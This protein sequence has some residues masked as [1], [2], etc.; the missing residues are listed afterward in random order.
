MQT[1]M[2]VMVPVF[3]GVIGQIFLKK[4]MME[5]GAFQFDSLT[6]IIPQFIKAFMN[7][8]VLFGFFMYFISSLFW[9][10]ILSKV[11]LS[12]AYPLLSVGYVLV[13]LAAW[14]IFNEAIPLIRWVGVGVIIFGVSLISQG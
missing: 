3:I 4:G 2:M 6:T 10:I 5:V 8:S 14:L 1:L 13:L 7:I 11:E 9:M 12:V